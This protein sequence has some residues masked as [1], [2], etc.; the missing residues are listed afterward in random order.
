MSQ[1]IR[2]APVRKSLIVRA[3]PEKAFRV[4]TEG[5]DR[6]WP[7]SHHI[8]KAP[9]ARGVLELRAGGRWYE[10]G[11][12][13]AECEWGEVLA[14]E[15]PRRLLLAWRLNAQWTYDPELHTEV[16]VTFTDVGAGETRVDLEHRGLER[17]GA[18]AET[19]RN[20]IDSPDGWGALLAAFKT[21]AE[22]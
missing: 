6:W 16:E 19:A 21:V 1:M 8:G 3:P 11:E 7:K 15:P 4:F 20:A 18:G 13:G 9:M 5:F 14:C 17:M 10:V 2:P 12:D 22:S